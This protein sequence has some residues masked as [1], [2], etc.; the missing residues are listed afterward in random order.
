MR[1]SSYGEATAPFRGLELVRRLNP[2]TGDAEPYGMTTVNGVVFFGA[3]DGHRPGLWR[4]DGTAEGTFL[5]K[6]VIVYP[7]FSFW[8]VGGFLFFYANDGAHGFELWRSDGTS[9]GTRMIADLNPGH[10]SSLPDFAPVVAN[11]SLYFMADDGF[12]GKSLWR[13]DGTRAG[14]VLI[15]QAQGVRQLA[16]VHDIVFFSDSTELWKTNGTT[17][18]TILVAQGL[19]FPWELTGVGNHLFFVNDDSLWKSDGTASGTLPVSSAMHQPR[20]LANVNGTLFFI[21]SYALTDSEELWK[22]DGTAAGTALLKRW[23][24]SNYQV[25]N[26]R[27]RIVRWCRIFHCQQSRAQIRIV[28]ERRY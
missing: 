24:P 19:N 23:D 15:K 6:N 8:N 13:S 28:A 7:Y 21:A 17:Q 26:T 14:T 1:E 11:G 9:A 16:A 22:S 10:E 27:V 2:D 20:S 4:S 25:I 12:N 18:G 5:V 3:F